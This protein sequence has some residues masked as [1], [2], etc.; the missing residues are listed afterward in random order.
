MTKLVLC[1]GID[2]DNPN[3]LCLNRGSCRRYTETIPTNK[4]CLMPGINVKDMGKC[5]FY[6]CSNDT[7]I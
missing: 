5:K 7:A 4:A 6:E 2:V 1:T 3:S